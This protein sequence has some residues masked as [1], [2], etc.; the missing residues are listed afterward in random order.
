MGN[1]RKSDGE[2]EKNAQKKGDEG[3]RERVRGVS[4]GE[5]KQ[6]N[7]D[8]NKMKGDG[9]KEKDGGEKGR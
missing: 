9:E 3:V 6:E 7:S 5:K 2:K 8:R 1:K 4:A